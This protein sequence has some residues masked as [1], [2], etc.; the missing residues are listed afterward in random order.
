MKTVEDPFVNEDPESREFYQRWKGILT[1]QITLETESDF[2]KLP[3]SDGEDLSDDPLYGLQ[4]KYE[5]LMNKKTQKRKHS[6]HDKAAPESGS[7]G[8]SYNNL[9][10]ML[11]HKLNS[12]VQDPDHFL[13]RREI[14]K[15]SDTRHKVTNV[16]Q[17]H[18]QW[19]RS[20]KMQVTT[21]PNFPRN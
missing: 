17:E 21:L 19:L 16:F 12:I 4:G 18:S 9:Q 1:N 20:L 3:S 15:S 8:Y 10:R 5:K 6:A 7:V 11:D 2:E 13:V 14:Y